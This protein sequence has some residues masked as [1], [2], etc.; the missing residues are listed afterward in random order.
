MKAS[1]FSDAHTRIESVSGGHVSTPGRGPF[2]S[3]HFDGHSMDR[4]SE[5]RRTDLPSARLETAV[6]PYVDPSGGVILIQF[7][8]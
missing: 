7:W 1:Q 6:D 2:R 5:R 4:K 3:W 8:V